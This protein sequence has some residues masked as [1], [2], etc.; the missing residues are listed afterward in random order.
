MIIQSSQV[1]WSSLL[2]GVSVGIGSS[3]D[4]DVGTLDVPI[5]GSMVQCSPSIGVHVV[6]VCLVLY[7]SNKRGALFLDVREDCL[8]DG[9]FSEDGEFVVDLVPAVDQVLNVLHVS[10]VGC[11]VQVLQ[12]TPHELVLPH[13]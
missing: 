10:L 5:V 3:L 8:V 2:V 9:G 6:H 1:H 4:E 11:V 13:F 12:D 7:N